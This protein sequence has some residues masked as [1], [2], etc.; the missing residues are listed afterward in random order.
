MNRTKKLL[1]FL[2]LVIGATFLLFK[3]L[4]TGNQSASIELKKELIPL[5]TVQPNSGFED[6]KPLKETLKDKQIIAMGEATH[7]TSEFFQMKHRMVEFLVEEMGYRVLAI[8][9]DFGAGQVINDY[10]LNGKSKAE[11]VLKTMKMWQ[12]DTEEVLS[13]IKWMR[14]FNE[15]PNHKEKVKFYG[16]DMQLKDENLNGVFK[17]LEKVDEII[18]KEFKEKLEKFHRNDAHIFTVNDFDYALTKLEELKS[19]FSENKEKYIKNT[20]ESEYEMALQHLIATSQYAKFFNAG[21]TSV[22]GYSESANNIRDQFM[23]ENIKWIIDYE[24]KSG[25]DKIMLWSHNTH[26]NKNSSRFTS[27]GELLNNL[28]GDKYYS[29]GF[30]FNTG[31]FNAIPMDSSGRRTDYLPH[32]FNIQEANPKVLS[33]TFKDTGIPISFIDFKSSIKNKKTNEL[34]SKTQTLHSVGNDFGEEIESRFYISTI[35][36]KT[37]DALIFISETTAAI[38]IRR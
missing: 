25:N 11:D 18:Y 23:T 9:G 14:E 31:S 15:D 3:G 28:Y 27:M 29:I 30:E 8:E 4:F 17:Y 6:L 10:I 5:K 22:D 12:W 7:G 19:V 24:S 21:V 35:P 26:V 34:I 36:A 33:L 32:K 20:S 38:P 1:I 13:L 37:F 2:L 16:F